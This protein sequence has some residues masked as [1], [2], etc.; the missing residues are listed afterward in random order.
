MKKV[1]RKSSC[2][3]TAAA[4]G[5]SL[6]ACDKPPPPPASPGLTPEG[7][8]S[9]SA[10]ATASPAPAAPSAGPDCSG[11][12]RFTEACGYGSPTRYAVL[13]PSAIRNA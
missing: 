13:D 11:K 7:S 10:P 5:L 4:L 9:S 12:D 2:V 3:G 1:I 8:E 6:A